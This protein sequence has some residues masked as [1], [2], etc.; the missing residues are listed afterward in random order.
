MERWAGKSP[1]VQACNVSVQVSDQIANLELI[2]RP[3]NPNRR[4]DCLRNI[5]AFILHG[6]ISE[7]DIETAR[8]AAAEAVASWTNPHPRYL[9]LA[10]FASERLAYLAIYQEHSPLHE[11]YSVA[12]GDYVNLSLDAFK[13]W[14]DQSR[15]GGLLAV[16]ASST[17][18]ELLGLGAV[19]K[20]EHVSLSS[21][22]S[23]AGTL[24]YEGERFG[25]AALIMLNVPKDYRL[26]NK[27][28]WNRFFCN[29]SRPTYSNHVALSDSIS[30]ITCFSHQVFATDAWLGLAIRKNE[31]ADYAKFCDEVNALANDTD[32]VS[33]ARDMSQDL[34]VLLP[35][36]CDTKR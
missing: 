4:S 6:T 10:N 7:T 19:T 2:V 16:V 8:T 27:P 11:L 36:R 17:D 34:Y 18:L 15:N 12:E 29:Q 14:V 9:T 32:V 28:I 22:R 20:S 13:Q 21:A 31:N 33:L 1:G 35:P 25:V 5:A 26:N 23:P 3:T 24:F 30:S